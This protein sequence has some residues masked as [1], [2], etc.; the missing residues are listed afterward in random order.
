MPWSCNRAAEDLQWPQACQKTEEMAP[1]GGDEA[2][3]APWSTDSQGLPH[4]QAQ[5]EP[6]QVD[7]Q[8]FE[9][10]ISV[11]EMNASHATGFI[12]MS[13]AAFHAFCS[14]LA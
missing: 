1:Q 10:V 12:G 9:D 2:R 8:T 5:I 11:S 3:E 4:E 6:A 13:K 14:G 7:Q